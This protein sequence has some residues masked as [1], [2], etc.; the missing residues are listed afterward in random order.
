MPSKKSDNIV[1]TFGRFNPVTI[2]HEKL[3][4][5]IDKIAS[6]LN[7]DA[8][9][10]T[11]QTQDKKRN[12]LSYDQKTHFLQKSFSSMID[13][14]TDKSKKTIFDVINGLLEEGYEKIYIVAGSDRV[15]DYDP[16]LRNTVDDQFRIDL[17]PPRTTRPEA[18]KKY[19]QV[20]EK[21]FQWLQ[22]HQTVTA[23]EIYDKYKIRRQTVGKKLKEMH[24]QGL[25]VLA[26]GKKKSFRLPDANSESGHDNL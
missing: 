2:G 24:A 21:V 25:L 23:T 17:F 16:F 26:A 15:S 14:V 20:A 8:R 11:S 1:F 5:K 10:Y 4:K 13:V 7:A 12:P 3:V 9:L 6:K 19:D 22:T 18:K